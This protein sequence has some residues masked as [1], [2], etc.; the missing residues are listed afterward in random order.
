MVPLSMVH[1]KS[2][3]VV[4]DGL[5]PVD[6]NDS[7]PPTIIIQADEPTSKGEESSP[8]DAEAAERAVRDVAAE[9]LVISNPVP[10]DLTV[11]SSHQQPMSW[12]DWYKVGL[13]LRNHL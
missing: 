1:M 9:K 11:L 13:S 10:P 6:I 2:V 5:I 4:P 8:Q 3:C 7:S 12:E